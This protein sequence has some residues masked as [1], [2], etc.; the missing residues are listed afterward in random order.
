M[1]N[2]TNKSGAAAAKT[3]PDWRAVRKQFPDG[4][5]A[6]LPQQRHE[7]DPAHVRGRGHAGVDRRRLRHRRR[8]CL[9]HGRHREDARRRGQDLRGAR[10]Y[11]LAHQE[12]VGG[13]EHHRPGLP[14]ARGR[15]CR[16][17]RHRAREQHLP[18]ALPQVARG[19]D[20][21]CQAGRAGPRD[22][23]LLSA[24]RRQAHTHPGARLGRLWQR[25]SRRPRRD[26][27]PS[28]ASAASSSSSTASRGS[29]CWRRRSRRSASTR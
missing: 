16:D 10:G 29:A 19:G 2:D 6:H 27:Q 17:Q 15:Q 5:Q 23:R 22:A 7:G 14:L 12:H 4:R 20:A 8:N 21:L 24:A 3:A 28:A 11:D 9:F 26:R 25:L 1:P 13:G 18:V